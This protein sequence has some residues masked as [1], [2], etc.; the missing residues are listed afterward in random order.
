MRRGRLPEAWKW[1]L[2]VIVG[3]GGDPRGVA[4][5]ALRG[6]ARCLQ[7]RGKG[8]GSALQLA[9]ARALRELTRSHGA[10]LVVNDRL[11]VALL[12]GADAVHLGAEDLPVEAARRIAGPGLCIGATAHSAA[13]VRDAA[14]RGADYVGFG[15]VYGTASKDGVPRSGLGGLAEAVSASPLPVL[16]I[17]GIGPGRAAAVMERGAAGAAVLSAV[18]AAADPA[19]VVRRLLREIRDAAPED[20]HGTA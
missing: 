1:R 20:D 5:A 17:G 2:C 18:A 8:K 4:A 11:D 7:Y 12:A 6:G 14:A 15:A 16:A 19:G 9:E 3:G 10:L 13:E